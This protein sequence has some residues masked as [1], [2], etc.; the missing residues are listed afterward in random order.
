VAEALELRPEI[1]YSE[2]LLPDGGDWIT[3][4]G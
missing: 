4:R 1:L 2:I 3:A